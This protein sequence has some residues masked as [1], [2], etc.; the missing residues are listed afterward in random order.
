MSQHE[1]PKVGKAPRL[2]S[3]GEDQMWAPEPKV[4]QAELLLYG[5]S[6]STV[7]LLG[8][9]ATS[10]ADA[11]SIACKKR[12]GWDDVPEEHADAELVAVLDT[13][14]QQTWA[15]YQ[16]ARHAYAVVAGDALVRQR[17]SAKSAGVIALPTASHMPSREG[18]ATSTSSINFAATGS[19]AAA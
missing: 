5:A 17:E 19:K 11:F 15:A 10:A 13:A 3:L 6:A 2:V 7:R 16:H 4:T 1:E 12:A 18:T 9:A 8:Q 14:V